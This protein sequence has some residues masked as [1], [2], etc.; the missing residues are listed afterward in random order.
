MKKLNT[1]EFTLVLEGV[2]D[3]TE[4]LEDHLFDVKCD[5]AL[6]NFR[7]GTVYLDFNREA[8]SL[9]DAVISA[10]KSIENSKLNAKVSRILPDELVNEADI[11]KRLD[12]S[13]QVIS[14]W[15]K[16]ERRQN[17][18]FPGPVL[19]LSDKSPLWRWHDVVKWLYEQQLIKD[20]HTVEAA[21]FIENINA[22]LGERDGTV[23]E[24]RHR[25]LGKL[26]GYRN[27]GNEKKHQA[28]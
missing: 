4:S 26:I 5:D 14:L 6:I 17:N 3:E 27:L 7:Y 1:F 11:A 20:R 25:I 16:K 9:E 15:V 23:R 24:S 10:I 28:L 13:R 22:I 12:K 18:P 19:K 21:H 2:N 8:E